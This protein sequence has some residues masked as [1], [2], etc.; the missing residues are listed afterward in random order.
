MIT[1]LVINYQS[2]LKSKMLNICSTIQTTNK[3]EVLLTQP[4]HEVL[5][6][7]PCDFLSVWQTIHEIRLQQSNIQNKF[8]QKVLDE[9]GQLKT[10][11]K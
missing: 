9:M 11:L 5:T 2:A 4:A 8:S 6:S 7:N 10:I 3:T 1:K